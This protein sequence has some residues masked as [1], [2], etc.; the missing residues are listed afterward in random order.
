MTSAQGHPTPDG[1]PFA[2]VDAFTTE[3]PFSGNPAGVVLLEEFPAD[4]WMQGVADELHQAETAFLVRAD[5]PGTFRLRHYPSKDA[6]AQALFA[7]GLHWYTDRLRHVA[8]SPGAP[9]DRLGA[10]VRGVLDAYREQPDAVIFV[11]IGTS[12]F[13]PRLEPGTRYPIEVVERVVADGQ[14]DG[15]VRDGPTNLIAAIL[16][17]CVLRPIIVATYASPGAL[18][19]LRSTDHDH[20]IEAAAIAAIRRP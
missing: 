13:V 18:D 4:E 17:G 2:I 10:I 14:A 9:L 19:L 8:E 16:L 5:E 15:T 1:T 11:L 3:R 12:S 7:R 20:T 6:L